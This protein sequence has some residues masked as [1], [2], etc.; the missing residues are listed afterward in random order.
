MRLTTSM[1]SFSQPFFTYLNRS[2]PIEDLP[3]NLYLNTNSLLKT[4]QRYTLFA[5]QAQTF[6]LFLQKRP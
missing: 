1:L 6:G 4:M 2:N 3:E 5:N